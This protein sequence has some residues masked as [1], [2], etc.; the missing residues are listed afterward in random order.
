M[1]TPIRFV[2][3]ILKQRFKYAGHQLTS[4]RNTHPNRPK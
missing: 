2:E 1:F 4:R 3:N